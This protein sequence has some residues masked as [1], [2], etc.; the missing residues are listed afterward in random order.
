MQEK[1]G[2]MYWKTH[3]FVQCTA[4]YTNKN[5]LIHA[6]HAKTLQLPNIRAIHYDMSYRLEIK[7]DC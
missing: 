7:I 4:M 5:A 3:V 1:H 2:R 6:L